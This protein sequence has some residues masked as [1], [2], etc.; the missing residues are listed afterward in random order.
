MKFSIYTMAAQSSSSNYEQIANV[1]EKLSVIFFVLAVICLALAIF[2]FIYFKIPEIIGDLSGR[3]AKKSIE[4]MRED[5]E[6]GGRKT[7]HPTPVAYDRGTI[8]RPIDDG[9]KETKKKKSKSGKLTQTQQPRN[10][11][12]EQTLPLADFDGTTPLNGAEQTT[13][14]G[15]DPAT[16]NMPYGDATAP[17]SQ[18][19]NATQV[20]NEGTQVLNQ[21]QQQTP[22]FQSAVSFKMIQDIVLVHTEEII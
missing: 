13:F 17:L 22:M 19:V 21:S 14:L 15:A 8:T 2:T 7:H 11:G 3:N 10:V 16:G 12:G 1:T 18:D 6:K 20:L 5:N 4:R 9:K